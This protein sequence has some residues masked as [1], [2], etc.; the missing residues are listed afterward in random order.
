MCLK[1][2]FWRSD[3]YLDLA[4]HSDLKSHWIHV[5][6][7]RALS[8]RRIS[9]LMMIIRPTSLAHFLKH[10]SISIVTISVTKIARLVSPARVLWFAPLVLC[11]FCQLYLKSSC[12]K[13][14]HVP[15]WFQFVRLPR[16]YFKS[17][18]FKV[19]DNPA[20]NT[21]TNGTS[22][23]TDN[24]KQKH[25]SMQV[26]D[27]NIKQRIYW[28]YTLLFAAILASLCSSETEPGFQ[29]I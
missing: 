9:V 29:S 27:R 28:C 1:N 16:S 6:Q 18:H 3:N 7:I 11:I 20:P 5:F 15:F 8:R 14:R 4:L 12:V 22:N 13:T 21:G 23:H 2:F 17:P 10:S 24:S 25:Q 19:D 26:S